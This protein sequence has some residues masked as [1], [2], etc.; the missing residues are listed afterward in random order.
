[1]AWEDLQGNTRRIITKFFAPQVGTHKLYP[2]AQ[3]G[4]PRACTLVSPQ[5][6]CT[7]LPQLSD[8]DT[9]AVQTKLDIVGNIMDIVLVSS[10]GLEK[11]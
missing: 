9:V 4:K 3:S 11:E 8:A 7:Y 10:T 2:G 6:N 1:M 5:I